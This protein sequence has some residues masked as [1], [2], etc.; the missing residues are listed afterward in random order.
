[1]TGFPDL[2][3]LVGLGAMHRTLMTASRSPPSTCCTVLMASLVRVPARG[4]V[5]DASIFMASMV[6][7]GWAATIESPSATVRV[8]TPENGAAT[9]DGSLRSAFS[10]AGACAATERS[11]TDTGRSCPLRMP[12]TVRIPASSG[13]EIASSPMTSST[14]FS[15]VTRWSSP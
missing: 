15:R 2:V 4:A 1:M 12:I 7:M 5:M 14:P 11:R 3:R 13:S 10:A 9:C 6:A 8:T